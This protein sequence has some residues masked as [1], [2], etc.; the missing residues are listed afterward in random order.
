MDN[1]WKKLH[2][3]L[4][5][6]RL[7]SHKA[8]VRH[9][10]ADGH[11]TAP[12]SH[13]NA[14]E[15]VFHPAGCGH[16]TTFP[17][18]GTGERIDFAPGDA[19]LYAPNL[20]H[21][22]VIDKGGEDWCVLATAP[23]GPRLRGCLRVPSISDTALCSEIESLAR[24]LSAEPDAYHGAPD[25]EKNEAMSDA[26][27]VLLDLRTSAIVLHL[28]NLAIAADSVERRHSKQFSLRAMRQ[29]EAAELY[30]Q[31]HHDEIESLA[32]VARHVDLSH[33]H[34]RHVFRQVRG[35]SLVRYLNEIRIIRARTL[36][37]NTV[38]PIKEIAGLCGF[39]DEYY[40]STQF[41]RFCFTT[42]GAYRE[43]HR[44][45]PPSVG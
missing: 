4:A 14:I 8:G 21:D 30:I 7:L 25:S 6:G 18:K 11:R 27:S 5:S 2:R 38:L 33:D 40:F 43:Q 19:V 36:L 10:L 24:S 41:R 1:G 28:L 9:R 13:P 42:P 3:Q 34:L 12:H 20:L 22:Q 39:C 37:A 29:V 44:A 16:T 31:Q 26:A 35:R 45:Q 23:P 17:D 32:E 15:I